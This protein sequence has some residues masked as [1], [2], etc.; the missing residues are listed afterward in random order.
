MFYRSVF[1]ATA[2]THDVEDPIVLDF[3]PFRIREDRT[4]FAPEGDTDLKPVFVEFEVDP[5]VRLRIP[6]EKS[7][8]AERR[9]KKKK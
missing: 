5:N 2:R 3:H 4:A 9:P 1:V 6:E 8:P 7:G